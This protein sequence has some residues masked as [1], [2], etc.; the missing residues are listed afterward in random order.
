[1][2]IESQ[3]PDQPFLEGS[4]RISPWEF[5][6]GLSENSGSPTRSNPLDYHQWLTGEGFSAIIEGWLPSL[7]GAKGSPFLVTSCA[8]K[9]PWLRLFVGVR[10]SCWCTWFPNLTLQHHL[11]DE[12]CNSSTRW[13]VLEEPVMPWTMMEEWWKNNGATWGPL[14]S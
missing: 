4:S 2:G 5:H 6:V 1:M 12:S 9:K 10:P 13:W 14:V 3:I 11:P 8:M 7:D